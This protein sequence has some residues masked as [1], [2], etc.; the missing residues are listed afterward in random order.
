[1]FVLDSKDLKLNYGKIGENE[2]T[3]KSIDLS[4][5]KSLRVNPKPGWF[6]LILPNRT[7]ELYSSRFDPTMLRTVTGEGPGAGPYESGIW[8]KAIKDCMRRAHTNAPQVYTKASAL[9]ESMGKDQAMAAATNESEDR[10]VTVA[11]AA[12]TDEDDIAQTI[13]R[14]KEMVHEIED[15]KE[16][17]TFENLLSE[18]DD[19]E[20][21]LDEMD[22]IPHNKEQEIKM[23]IRTHRRRIE[24]AQ[25]SLRK[26]NTGS[27][28][29]DSVAIA[30]SKTSDETKDESMPK[31]EM[32]S[33]KV[34]PKPFASL[35]VIDDS[36]A[37]PKPDPKPGPEPGLEP[38]D[39]PSQPH[40][41]PADPQLETKN[42]DI[43]GEKVTGQE[44][45]S[46][47]SEADC[48]RLVGI[49]AMALCPCLKHSGAEVQDEIAVHAQIEDGTHD[50]AD[51]ASKNEMVHNRVGEVMHGVVRASKQK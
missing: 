38:A 39:L 27:G 32:I 15:A 19:M 29:P 11:T 25:Q 20:D 24:S 43:I 42:V 30:E 4:M 23:E 45:R 51:I 31:K 50:G 26:G 12:A 21:E 13:H 7:Y 47:G 37:D 2:E 5:V 6:E 33:E 48:L 36:S 49:I 46:N 28:P 1:M 17:T 14:L 16:L 8:I 44:I 40:P 10:A 3:F 41:H 35:I 9:D 18:M 22:E 34:D